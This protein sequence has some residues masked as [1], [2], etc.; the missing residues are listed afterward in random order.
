M[1]DLNIDIT[2]LGTQNFVV[3][4]RN[5][6]VEVIDSVAD[7]LEL[8]KSIFDFEKLKLLIKGN[9]N[10]KP[11]KLLINSMHGGEYYFKFSWFWV[12]VFFLN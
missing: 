1:P 3:D 11:F 8:M 10:R 4:G 12:L 9:E 6:T 7:Y 2:K 5:F